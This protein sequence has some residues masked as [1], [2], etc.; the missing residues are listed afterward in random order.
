M[1]FLAEQIT[2]QDEQ[3]L[4]QICS[5]TY[6][7][8]AANIGTYTGRSAFTIARHTHEKLYC[9][10]TFTGSGSIACPMTDSYARDDV[11]SAF[12]KNVEEFERKEIIEILKMNS[13]SAAGLLS[14]CR[15]SKLDLVFIDADHS[16]SHVAQ[17]IAA[18]QRLIRKG[19][20]ICG[21]DFEGHAREFNQERMMQFCEQD[22]A[23][24]V[25]YGV[26]RAVSEA[27]PDVIRVGRCWYSFVN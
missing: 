8:S 16:Y 19:G 7:E 21:H 17:D 10:D 26:I 24:G 5:L 14:G 22:T 2:D 18:W 1:N 13:V 23:D 4:N 9:V 12:K 11:F 15:S 3:D 25:H 27:L 6:I 20:I